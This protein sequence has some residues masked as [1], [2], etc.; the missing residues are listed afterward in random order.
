ML[1][2][3]SGFEHLQA[4]EKEGEEQIVASTKEHCHNAQQAINKVHPSHGVSWYN[5]SVCVLGL[6]YADIGQG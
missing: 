1:V 3:F 5:G 4:K 6:L 2:C